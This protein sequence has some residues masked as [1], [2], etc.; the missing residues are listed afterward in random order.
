MTYAWIIT[1]DHLFSDEGLPALQ[2]EAGTTGPRDAP[3][4]LLARLA[5]GEGRT[6]R[7]YDDDGELYYTGRILTGDV[8]GSEDDFG[9]LADFGTPNAGCTEIRYRAGGRWVTL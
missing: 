6:F 2:D 4:G 5:G 8:P 3:A 7:M 9:P 1:T